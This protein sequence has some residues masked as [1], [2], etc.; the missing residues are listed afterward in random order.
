MHALTLLEKD[1]ARVKE[2]LGELEGLGDSRPRD[3]ERLFG[4]IRAELT[5]HEIIE[6][7]IFY[8]ALKSHPKA[9][10]I[11]LEGIEEHNVVDTLLGELSKLPP[12][13]ETWAPKAKVMKENVEHHIGEEEGEMFA[14]ARR[15][16]DRSELDD[17]GAQME[18]RKASART[19]VDREEAERDRPGG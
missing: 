19:D 12:E 6:E 8:P 16:F 2:L 18:E 5:V 4:R 10:D 1:H 13:D 9:K 15:V 7:E 17:L 11:V 3:R 14:A